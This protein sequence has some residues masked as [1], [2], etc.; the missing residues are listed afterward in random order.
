MRCTRNVEK[1]VKG[2]PHRTRKGCA[3]ESWFQ[4]LYYWVT[5]WYNVIMNDH[6]WFWII[7]LVYNSKVDD[8]TDRSNFNFSLTNNQ[9]FNVHKRTEV[10]IEKKIVFSTAV[11]ATKFSFNQLPIWS[12]ARHRRITSMAI[13]VA[14]DRVH[15]SVFFFFFLST[16]R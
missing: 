16:I 5:P 9:F 1:Y 14:D 6:H 15:A 3:V 4:L 11:H 13:A 10:F 2:T 8:I 12:R 7:I